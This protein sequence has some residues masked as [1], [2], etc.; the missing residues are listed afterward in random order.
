[1]P[2]PPVFPYD[3]RMSPVPP[4]I[5]DLMQ[6]FVSNTPGLVY[7]F[8]LHADGRVEFPYLSD[9]CAALLGLPASELQAAPGRFLELIV[10]DDR[11]SYLDAMHASATALSGWNWEGRIWIDEYK[12][13][14]WIN[15]RST[16]HA[17]T[18]QPGSVHAIP[19]G[20][21]V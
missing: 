21:P 17:L 11:R 14:K 18:A 12:D 5:A 7:Q 10:P 4:N 15:L 8:I 3:P 19:A 13:Q 1:M 6:A 20:F 9:G 16:P 2:S